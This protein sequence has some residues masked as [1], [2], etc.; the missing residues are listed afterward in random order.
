MRLRVPLP[1]HPGALHQLTTILAAEHAN[2]VQVIHDCA[3]FGMH[4][5]EGSSISRSTF[6]AR[7][8]WTI[9]WTNSG[10]R[11]IIRSA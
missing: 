8:T 11:A 7:S 9:Y 1:D 4:L 10:R 2:I 6:V 3:Y 5:G